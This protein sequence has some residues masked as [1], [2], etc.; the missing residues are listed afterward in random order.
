M[1]AKHLNIECH[2]IPSSDSELLRADVRTHTQ[3]WQ[4]Q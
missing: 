4:K 3:A 1:V 2:E